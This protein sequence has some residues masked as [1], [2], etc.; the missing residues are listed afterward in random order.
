MLPGDNPRHQFNLRSYW[1]LPLA[2]EFDTTVFYTGH[3]PGQ[4]LPAYTRL[5][6]RLGWRPAK[7]LEFSFLLQNLLDPHHTEFVQVYDV[8]GPAQV[9]RSILGKITWRCGA[10]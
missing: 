7:N 2:L 4:P 9:G 5:D 3:L 8:Q 1:S 10:R 6:T